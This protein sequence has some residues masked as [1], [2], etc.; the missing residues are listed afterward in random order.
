MK[1]IVIYPY[2]AEN[3]YQSDIESNIGSHDINFINVDF[4]DIKNIIFFIL[5]IRKAAII[6]F[7]W[8]NNIT[9]TKNTLLSATLALIFFVSLIYNL[10]FVKN[11]II[12]TMHNRR[13]HYNKLAFLDNL[14]TK[15]IIF[16]SRY[17]IVHAEFQKQYVNLK[18]RKK[19]DNIIVMKHGVYKLPCLH[20]LD[21]RSSSNDMPVFL[22]FG[23][24]SEYKN[25]LEVA[26]ILVGQ[27]CKLIILGRC[28]SD[29][30]TNE[31][32]SLIQKNPRSIEWD[33]RDFTEEELI[34][35]SCEANF[36]LLPQP[37]VFTSGSAILALSLAKPILAHRSE[38]Y[39][40]IFKGCVVQ[41]NDVDSLMQIDI[42]LGALNEM[43]IEDLKL[44]EKEYKWSKTIVPL[45]A[46]YE[47]LL[48]S[49]C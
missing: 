29:A 30:M 33:N 46:I 10:L 44:L 23:R 19:L 26:R 34:L 11:D 47:N 9:Q 7:H 20:Q 15:F 27:N 25:V 45:E 43:C 1:N 2:Y 37:N 21:D 24:V 3:P 18:Y 48:Y 28:N 17:V 6:H 16:V 22:Y 39:S 35:K 4:K 38:F 5:G 32:L 49:K 36:I 42:Y 31:I 12:Y 14:L 41:Y 8:I 13:S 40:E